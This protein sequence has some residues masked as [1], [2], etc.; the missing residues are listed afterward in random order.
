VQAYRV[1]AEG[2]T[3]AIEQALRAAEIGPQ[4]IGCVIA[5]ASGSPAGDEMEIRALRNVFGARLE[6]IPVCAPKAAFGEALGASGAL[7]ALTAGLALA[8]GSVPPVALLSS[9]R[10]V[11]GA[12]ALVNC[13]GCDGNNAALVLKGLN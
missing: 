2:A 3:S 4:E 13:F 5:C 7:C 10:S 9:L 1:R 11:D 12:Y 8:C 6:S